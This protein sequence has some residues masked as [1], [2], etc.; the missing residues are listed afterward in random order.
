M[1]RSRTLRALLTAASLAVSGATAAHALDLPTALR[2]ALAANPGLAARR[3]MA[4]AA[5]ARVAP[6]GAW[7][8]PMLELGVVNVP[9]SGRFDMEMMTMRMVGLAQRVPVSGANRLMRRAADASA[10]A[11]GADA[12]Q[13]RLSLVGAVWDAYSEAYAAERL[14]ADAFA[15]RG[16]MDRLVEAAR[17]RHRAGNGRLDEVLRAEAERAR[18][19]ADE[20]RFGA[21]ARGARARLDALRGVEPRAPDAPL[22]PPPAPSVPERADALLA[23]AAGDHPRLRALDASAARWRLEARAARRMVWPDLDLRAS[24]GFREKLMGTVPQDDMW[25]ASVGF[26][27]P[28]FARSRE[29]AEGRAMDAMAFAA[30]AERLEGA[31]DLAR[32]VTA[33]HADARAAART[34]ALL[35]DTVVAAQRLSLDAAWSAYAAGQLDLAR[36]LDSAHAFYAE[37]QSLIR[38]DQD[39][40]RAAGRLIALTGRADLVGLDLP[41]DRE[42]GTR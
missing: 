32:E 28:V 26:M 33:A 23:A 39:L 21:A 25:S 24:M 10:R 9:P 17:A 12:D 14:E 1:D 11:A 37:E 15:H 2:D 4:D 30:D 13:A 36:V 27:L 42:E 3:A 34:V 6:A 29:L 40:A 20:V 19:L 35:A 5:R 41:R 22:E 38:A 18:V 8:P 7:S 16:E 31:L